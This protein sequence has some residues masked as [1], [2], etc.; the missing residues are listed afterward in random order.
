M[1]QGVKYLDLIA[2]KTGTPR[3]ITTVQ[4]PTCGDL[5]SGD[6]VEVYS[7]SHKVAEG[8]VME[9][10]SDDGKNMVIKIDER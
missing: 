1:K 6:Q 3:G 7:D 5:H 4:V 9:I 10:L 2:I 8:A